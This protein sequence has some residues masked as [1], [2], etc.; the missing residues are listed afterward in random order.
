MKTISKKD[1]ET[2]KVVETKA[3]QLNRSYGVMN[4]TLEIIAKNLK[5]GNTDSLKA[6]QA[7]ATKSSDKQTVVVNPAQPDIKITPDIKV[8]QVAAPKIIVNVEDRKKTFEFEI[9]R[10]RRTHLINRIVA[11]EVS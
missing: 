11:K 9:S 7:I 2:G 10:D 6:L 4:A 3:S 5:E 8:P 1:L